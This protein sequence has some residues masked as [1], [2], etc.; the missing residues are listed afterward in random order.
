MLQQIDESI[1][2]FLNGLH[3]AYFDAF[4]WCGTNTWTYL[5]LYIAIVW[6]LYKQYGNKIWLPVLFIIL[7]VL[8]TDQI[9]NLIKGAIQRLRPTHNPVVAPFI[10]TVNDY[11]GG[12]YSFP[13]G[14]ACNIFGMALFLYRIITPKRWILTV[15]LF[16]WAGIT[17]YSRI[18][19]GVHYPGD[20]LAGI[21]LGGL[22]GYF[23]SW[24][25][26]RIYKKVKYAPR[27]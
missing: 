25:M 19:L 10:H 22:I 11:R 16:A 26:S 4:F 21:I 1:L 27:V 6:L 5:P 17:A 12:F 2:F 15:A 18:Y 23:T 9:T 14:H 24:L 8:L 7:T 13:S 3:N 20:I